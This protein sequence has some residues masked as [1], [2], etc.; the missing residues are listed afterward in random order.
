MHLSLKSSP[1]FPEMHGLP[2]TEN[3]IVRA[4]KSDQ[5]YHAHSMA[6]LEYLLKVGERKVRISEGFSLKLHSTL[7]SCIPKEIRHYSIQ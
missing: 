1:L 7:I 3:T 5:R 2:L 4:M 6:Y